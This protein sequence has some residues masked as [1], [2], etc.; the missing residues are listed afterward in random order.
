M[1]VFSD[2]VYAEMVFGRPHLSIATL[3]GMR[4]RTVVLHSLSKSHSL[5]G[6]RIGFCAAPASVVAAG[7]RVSVHSAFNMPVLLQHVALAALSD[8]AYTADSRVAFHAARDEAARRLVGSGVSFY[9]ADGGAYLFLDFTAHLR[10][11]PLSVLLEAAVER[12]VL[13]AP[14]DAFG[15]GWGA[16][17][18]LCYTSVPV[19]R[20]NAGVD[21]LVD[22][23][24]STR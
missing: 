9:L 24:H 1:W 19:E 21:R 8:L 6:A 14:G 5:A 23:I 22:A 20:L 12:G 15:D 4:A 3:P 2:E 16:H 10:G 13:L 18:R 17:A 7:R 11:R